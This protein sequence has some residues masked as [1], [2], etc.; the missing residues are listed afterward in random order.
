MTEGRSIPRMAFSNLETA[1]LLAC[2]TLYK[3]N[4]LQ[5]RSA[6]QRRRGSNCHP[7]V[8]GAVARPSSRKISLLMEFSR[9][10][11]AQHPTGFLDLVRPCFGCRQVHFPRLCAFASNGM[12]MDEVPDMWRSRRFHVT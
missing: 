10:G 11:K 12:E 6:L 5:M 8:R 3:Y 9:G 7:P 4:T 2:N 1:V